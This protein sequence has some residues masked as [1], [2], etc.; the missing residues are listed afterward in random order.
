MWTVNRKLIVHNSYRFYSLH[1]STSSSKASPFFTSAMHF[2]VF[3]RLNNESIYPK[4]LMIILQKRNQTS[5][6][7][8]Y[9]TL[10]SASEKLHV[11]E[12]TQSLESTWFSSNWSPKTYKSQLLYIHC[13]VLAWN[14]LQLRLRFLENQLFLNHATF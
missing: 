11:F 9:C 7:L 4:T 1:L 2:F 6:W 12:I 3:S 14:S 13:K 5:G 8:R 10:H